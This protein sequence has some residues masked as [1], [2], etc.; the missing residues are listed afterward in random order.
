MNNWTPYFREKCKPFF[1]T[2]TTL[3]FLSFFSLTSHAGPAPRSLSGLLPT[4]AIRA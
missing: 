4:V 2:L 1:L 3:F